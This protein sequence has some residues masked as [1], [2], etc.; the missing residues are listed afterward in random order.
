MS[1][2]EDLKRILLKIEGRGYKAYKE[3]T[4]SYAFDS[5]DLIIDH[6]QSDPFALP[7]RFRVHISHKG[8][9]FPAD[10]FKNKSREIGL[11]DFLARQFARQS[12]EISKGNRGTGKSGLISID[13]PGQEVLERTSVLIGKENIEVRF[14][15]GLPARGRTVLTKVAES[16]L[17]KEVPQI[18]S[19]SMF[20][21]EL[22][23]KK[24]YAHIETVE[25][26]D[27]LRDRLSGLGLI[28]FVADGAVLPRAS[29][30]DSR[31]LSK[32]KIVPF[33]SP[34][35]MKVSVNLPNRG[36]IMGMGMREGVTLIVGGGYHGKSTLLD[37]LKLGIYNHLPGD[38][39]E[40]VVT[41]ENAVMIR[42]E[43]GRRIEGVDI[44]PFINNLP[45]GQDTKS[46][47]TD[48]ASGSTS[49]AANI[50]E[51]LEMGSSAVLI[52]EDTSATN[53][54]IRDHRM[55][56]LI[57][58]DLEPITPFID[59]VRQLYQDHG[60]ST[61][62]VIGGS[63]DYFDVADYV[64]S[65]KEYVPEDC[66]A[67]AKA[68]A[69][70]Y[71]TEREREGGEVF[72]AFGVRV[73]MKESFDP[74]R[75]KR[76]VKI[77]PKGL[78]SIVFGRNDIDLGAVEQLVDMSQTRAMGEAIHYATK[79]MDN[80][81][82]LKDVIGRVMSDLDKSGLDALNKN[83]FGDYAVFRK[84]ELASAINRLRTVKVV[85]KI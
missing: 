7:S 53:F 65:M 10:T 59:K 42:A 74:S 56:E 50:M 15:V 60:V 66:T 84:Y 70:K 40:F 82:T 39:R 36:L 24:L 45:Y 68:I 63:G 1:N 30:I 9:G 17:L 52:D 71:R 19:S 57:S 55:Q 21:S 44:S 51:A 33:E 38:G 64:I 77:S 11:R 27:F 35:S 4:G 16:M 12:R 79:Y 67:D 22:D 25:D 34:A 46:F 72:G 37:A 23:D 58:K 78:L 43:D 5:F 14:V 76:D 2:K 61:V 20:F 48:N 54:M 18:I 73:P 26:A 75:G 6:V 32:G 29:G 13:T 47:C 8:A 69:E 83:K 81:R 41:T 3:L 49:Q 85:Q 80:K 31:P 28:S 62:L